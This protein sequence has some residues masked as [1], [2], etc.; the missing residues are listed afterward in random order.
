MAALD[1]FGEKHFGFVTREN[2]DHPM[3]RKT[4]QPLNFQPKVANETGC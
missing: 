1:R 4:P 2:L 3:S